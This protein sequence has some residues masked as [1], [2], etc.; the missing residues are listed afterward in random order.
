M[1][2]END[3]EAYEQETTMISHFSSEGNQETDM[4][5]TIEEDGI[6]K[7][8][9]VILDLEECIAQIKTMLRENDEEAY[10]EEAATTYHLSSKGKQ[11]TIV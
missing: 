2:R 5:P 4:A 3:E 10:E 11:E 8:L 9:V 1:L 6:N 7:E